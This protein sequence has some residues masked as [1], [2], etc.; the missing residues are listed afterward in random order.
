MGPVTRCARGGLAALA[1]LCGLR[2]AAAQQTTPPP[3]ELGE[4][5][6]SAG[7][8]VSELTATTRR[9]TAADI[10]A[11]GARTLDEAI[12]LL[13]G[14]YVR[15]GGDGVPRIDLRGFRTRQVT[16]LL[17]GVPL[18]AT[19]DG[20]FDPSFIPVEEIAE[21]KLTSGTAS[22]LY[23]SGGLAGAINIVT[24]TG[25]G[26]PNATGRGE[27]R[28][29]DGWLGRL[30]G[31]G[32]GGP[33]TVFVAASGTSIGGLPSVDGSPTLGAVG[34]RQ[35]L[36]SDRER[37]N[38][39][40]RFGLALSPSAAAGL[41]LQTV[42]GEYG[43]PPSVIDDPA[44][45]FANRP[46]YERVTDLDG[47]A[48]QLG[49]SYVPAAEWSVRGWVYRNLLNQLTDRFADAGFDPVTVLTEVG[50]SRDRSRSL[51][52]GV[53]LQVSTTAFPIG[54]VTVG[55]T[56]DRSRWE[57]SLLEAVAPPG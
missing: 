24:R 10:E 20:Q 17:D 5:V 42:N 8:P 30:T 1:L 6:V 9:V 54:R 55:L 11:Y 26:R 18:N 56:A 3:Q 22:V 37:L 25:E 2:A 19:S 12:G 31:S 40:G 38:L 23:G 53:A 41:T 43:T 45:P 32:A 51:L 48:A 15:S 39:S 52:T 50:T 28:D 29:S 35:R 36:N 27:W 49:G 7:D 33:V 46:V 44:D 16:L 13:P 47:L 4:I 34:S 21:I 14:V 57:E